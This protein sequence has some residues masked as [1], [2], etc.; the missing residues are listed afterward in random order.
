MPVNPTL[1]QGSSLALPN[2]PTAFGAATFEP[3][4]FQ[5][6]TFRP[7]SFQP[8]QFGQFSPQDV[9]GLKEEEQSGN[10][11]LD[12]LTLPEIVFGGRMIRG[13]VYSVLENEGV[14]GFFE[15]LW[16]GSP[17]AHLGEFLT[18]ADLAENVTGE[19]I[20]RAAGVEDPGFFSTLITEIVLDP[21][22]Y[23]AI[24]ALS[25]MGQAAKAGQVFRVMAGAGDDLLNLGTR[26][27]EDLVQFAG[28]EAHAAARAA[29]EAG[30][31][32]RVPSDFGKTMSLA[33]QVREGYRSGFRLEIPFTNIGI[34]VGSR[35]F[36]NSFMN[37]VEQ[38]FEGLKRT[39]LVQAL[40]SKSQLVAPIGVNATEEAIE[41]SRNLNGIVVDL[42]HAT[43]GANNVVEEFVSLYNEVADLVDPRLRKSAL[44]LKEWGYAEVGAE[45][46]P[47]L[48][49]RMM[50]NRMRDIVGDSAAADL[51]EAF[52][53]GG[54][55]ASK[56]D[57][58]KTVEGSLSQTL[59]RE[60]FVGLQTAT[61]TAAEA[62]TQ[63]RNAKKG[64]GGKLLD[65]AVG[66]D[67]A[68]SHFDDLF[69]LGDIPEVRELSHYFDLTHFVERRTM[70]LMDDA[71]RLDSII[72]VDKLEAVKQL[73][74]FKRLKAE[75]R[76]TDEAIDALIDYRKVYDQFGGELDEDL[77][78]TVVG[79][80]N[81]PEGLRQAV[82]HGVQGIA[83]IRAT[84]GEII[85]QGLDAMDALAQEGATPIAL[86]ERAKLRPKAKKLAKIVQDGAD[87]NLNDVEAVIRRVVEGG[88]MTQREALESMIYIADSVLHRAWRAEQAAGI[89]SHML[90]HYAPHVT[91]PEARSFLNG[92]FKEAYKDNPLANEWFTKHR[93]FTNRTTA[94]VNALVSVKGTD[95]TGNI[96][97]DV[98]HGMG[99][100][101][102]KVRKAFDAADP[103][104]LEKLE[105][106]DPAAAQFFQSDLSVAVQA[107]LN[108]S[109]RAMNQRQLADA[110]LAPFGEGGIASKSFTVADEAAA[111][112]VKT[113]V[114]DFFA[115]RGPD[116]KII[117]EN[118]GFGPVRL[119]PGKLREYTVVRQDEFLKPNFYDPQKVFDD[120]YLRSASYGYAA[121]D[122][123]TNIQDIVQAQEYQRELIRRDAAIVNQAKTGTLTIDPTK[124]LQLAKG[125]RLSIVP[126][127]VANELLS[128]HQK[129]TSPVELGW[130]TRL[131][132]KATDMWKW[133][134]TV[135]NPGFHARNFASN[136][137]MAWMAGLG[138]RTG[139]KRLGESI[140][141]Q[142]AIAGMGRR[143]LEEIVFENVN[144]ETLDA[145]NWLR[146]MKEQG[147]IDPAFHQLETYKG[148]EQTVDQTVNKGKPKW[149]SWLAPAESAFD[150]MKDSAVAQAVGSAGEKINSVGS[151]IE[152]LWRNAIALDQWHKG[153]TPL[154]AARH[155]KKF[156]VD[157]DSHLLTHT[158]RGLF[159]AII[160]F[161]V[162]WRRNV[163]LVVENM[164][165]SPQKFNFVGKALRAWETQPEMFNGKSPDELPAELVP[166]FVRDF[167]GVPFRV[168]K[169]G[170]PEYFLL[171]GWI[172]AADLAEVA[173]GF[174]NAARGVSRFVGD[175]QAPM[176]EDSA[177]AV[178]DV[179]SRVTPFIKLP[180]EFWFNYSTFTEKDIQR[181]E[182]QQSEVFGMTF[183]PQTA[184]LL[185]SIALVNNID[186]LNLGG[187]PRS[188]EKGERG[189]V[190]T[191]LRLL[192]FLTGLKSVEGQPVEE[193]GRSI[194]ELE[195]ENARLKGEYN[196]LALNVLTP[197][198]DEQMDA[199]RKVMR[200]NASRI[201]AIQRQKV[202]IQRSNRLAASATAN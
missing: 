30:Q 157:Y 124:P 39:K 139:L 172:P 199:L 37:A 197:G 149:L 123:P 119:D 49:G 131:I 125:D 158:E 146:L 73:D 202:E 164:I 182:G 10:F 63:L 112:R 69:R 100:M 15:R 176:N 92:L 55:K 115:M 171:K 33:R 53:A 82:D 148:I 90:E 94:E 129:M 109:A 141:I 84:V 168:N 11:F 165:E 43:T 122:L 187:V 154:E 57:I 179:V 26:V 120:T 162:F 3:A 118:G 103:K 59:E 106:L 108:A 87:T 127:N 177:K 200:E 47:P 89:P 22:S 41:Q 19:D 150:K 145:A 153:A 132:H 60:G 183:S 62:I 173:E 140:E 156:M 48:V 17:I 136:A 68:I 181:F 170:N 151:S 8:A 96:P 13:A 175:R 54:F 110:I 155:A 95:F 198:R 102:T 133:T 75:G 101:T 83:D 40:T 194:Y 152:N 31:L 81:L 64:L 191:Y 46:S 38:S 44:T 138:P 77:A 169:D 5:P 104:W 128:V 24:G 6:A 105:K 88:E 74:V 111:G 36:N 45:L 130:L 1:Q 193:A 190:N 25:K 16:R 99:E 126:N 80:V 116:G 147:V 160:P 163:P 192:Q 52:K 86:S 18:G 35:S 167:Y 9:L 56:V 20:L 114:L 196:R 91:N 76:I 70:A 97:F 21:S 117:R 29:A 161:Y 186:K 185:R 51:Y 188:G 137:W 184:T 14:G 134:A 189:E 32:A 85:D 78:R 7:A 23:L 195:R 159:R 12:L 42:A 107:R 2:E 71:G 142:K 144:G 66:A 67:E 178:K 143:K 93:L 135:P 180:A 113:E 4:S 72:D 65:A 201:I 166:D 50:F 79:Y 27:G 98:F 61:A 121:D 28:K 58:Q 34:D 174:R